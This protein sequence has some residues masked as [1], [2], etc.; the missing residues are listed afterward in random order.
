MPKLIER[1]KKCSNTFTQNYFASFVALNRVNNRGSITPNPASDITLSKQRL[2]LST[3]LYWRLLE[4]ILRDELRR[5]KTLNMS[6]RR[7]LFKY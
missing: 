3:S 7:K 1:I 6:V 5:K 4:N 2:Q